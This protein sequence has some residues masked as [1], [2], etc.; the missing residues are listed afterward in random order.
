MLLL[1]NKNTKFV[2]TKLKLSIYSFHIKKTNF[3]NIQNNYIFIL[4][5][6]FVRII[7]M[8]L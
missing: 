6:I 7:V 2:S 1:T 3:S 5:Y 4:L 8:L